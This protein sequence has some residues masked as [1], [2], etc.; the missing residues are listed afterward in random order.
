MVCALLIWHILNRLKIPCAWLA[1]VIFAIHPVNVE[2]AAWIAQRKNLL[3]MFFFLVTLL[4]Y[5]QFDVDGRRK[6]Y[7]LAVVS[8]VLAMLSKGAV[9]MLP[10]V[11]L[12]CV[13]WL[14]G[15]I[16][17]RDVMQSLAFFAVSAIMGVVELWF[18]TVNVIGETVVRDDTFL[19]RIAGAGWVVWFYLYKAMLPVNL[20]FVYPRWEINTANW[21]SYLPDLALI[22]LLVLFWYYRRSW[23]R[24]ILFAL[25]YFVVMV[26]PATGFAH[27]YFLKY[28]FVADHYQYM[29]IIG[30]I[31]FVAAAGY[32]VA[33][34]LGEKATAVM[35]WISVFIV[36]TFGI[37]SW[38]Q[39]GIYKD[40]EVLWLDTLRKNPDAWMAHNNLGALLQVRGKLGEAVDHY[41]HALRIKPDHA[42]SLN[43]IGIILSIQGKLDEAADYYLHALQT[44]PDFEQAH[45]NLANV[46]RSQGKFNEAFSHYRKAL[47]IEP[48]NA[49]THHAL[50]ILLVQGGRLDEAVEHFRQAAQIRPDYFEVHYNLGN[51]FKSQGKLEQAVNHYRK[52]L[53]IRADNAEL[54]NNFGVVLK[55]QGKLD[56]AISCYREA[57]R[58]KPDYARAYNNFGGALLAQDKIEDAIKHFNQALQIEPDYTEALRNLNIALRLRDGSD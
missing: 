23:G 46:L 25:G 18:Q 56:E 34:R 42:E 48:D 8:F 53:Q 13:W 44:K 32:F 1:A 12:M 29:A 49:D 14:H 40:V 22:F 3:S 33:N 45:Y 31:A 15:T 35:K 54:Y 37:L 58:I 6:W 27:F 9:V 20:C 47:Q 55:L 17:R 19:A 41:Q 43:N 36:V 38:Q 7:C 10:V 52:A 21:I 39:S 30:V 4:L 11:V 28:S 50:A 5:L 51:V 24:S 2:S 26:A 16:T 57:L